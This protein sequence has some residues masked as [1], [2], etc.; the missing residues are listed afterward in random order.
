MH[1]HSKWDSMSQCVCQK[2]SER[3]YQQLFMDE[4][5]I[6]AETVGTGTHPPMK[7]NEIWS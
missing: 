6:L 3:D 2:S 5:F 7:F 4:S 1:F